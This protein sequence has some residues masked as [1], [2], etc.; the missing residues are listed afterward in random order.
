MKQQQKLR[1]TA[2]YYWMRKICHLARGTTFVVKLIPQADFD[3]DV[4]KKKM[5]TFIDKSSWNNP[6]KGMTK[7][8]IIADLRR[9]REEM[10]A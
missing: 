2:I 9:Q 8:E 1:K 6:F 7:E 3:P 4:F 10:Y 5:Q